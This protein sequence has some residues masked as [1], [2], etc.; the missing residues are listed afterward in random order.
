MSKLS[1]HQK[2][3]LKETTIAWFFVIL[4]CHLFYQLKNVPFIKENISLLSAV[5]MLYIPIGI[6]LRKREKINYLDS[7]LK[8]FGRSL[9]LFILVSIVI[10]PLII[11]GNH[12]YQLLFIKFTYHPS[13]FNKLGET[14]L[15]QL[16]LIS[17]PEEFFFRGYLLGR[18]NQIFSRRWRFLGASFGPGLLW[19][20]LLF[21]LSHSLILVQWWHIFIFFPALVFGWLREKTGTLTAPILFHALSNLFSHWVGMHYF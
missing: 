3:L 15:F 2:S 4:L 1:N 9:L 8:D 14:I 21:A 7:S 17:L 11:L 10:F 20:S 16:L 6:Y 12:Y 18:F 5:V 19:V 13:A